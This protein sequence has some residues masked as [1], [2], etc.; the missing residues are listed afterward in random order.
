MMNQRP[1][2]EPLVEQGQPLTHAD[3]AAALARIDQ[4]LEDGAG[5]ITEFKAHVAD[6]SKQSKMVENRLS[7]LE[8]Q[9]SQLLDVYRHIRTG[10]WSL[11]TALVLIG[12][13]IVV[14]LLRL[15][16]PTP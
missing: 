8:V 16:A 11:A 9:A 14:A 4:R 13:G 5:D 3:I 2:H 12:G 1:Q 15:T 6:C 10:V 7:A